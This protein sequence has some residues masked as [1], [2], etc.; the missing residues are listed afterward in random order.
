MSTPQDLRRL[1]LGWPE[2]YEDLHRGKP[3]FRVNQ[4]IFALLA[5]PGQGF[6]GLDADSS[7][8]LK[9]DRHDQLAFCEMLA[10]H[11]RETER[12][13]H[14]GW[15]YLTLP[16]LSLPDLATLVGLAWA[17]VAP[18]RLVKAV[19]HGLNPQGD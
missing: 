8:V 3:A 5:A 16:E 17:H 12:Y 19:A 7:A 9:L 14:H 4:K 2:A 15:T 1:A 18:R 11:V 10:P 6:M 13:G